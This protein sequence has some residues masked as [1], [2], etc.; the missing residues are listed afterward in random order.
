MVLLY[1]GYIQSVRKCQG[2]VDECRCGNLNKDDLTSENNNQLKIT[3]WKRYIDDI[4]CITENNNTTSILNFLN[5]IKPFLTFTHEIEEKNSLS[6]LDIILTRN[7]SKIETGIYR[8]KT[9]TGGYLNFS[10]FGPI[11]HKISVIKTLSK[12]ISTHCSNNLEKAQQERTILL[13]ELQSNSYPTEFIKR[14]FHRSTF[15]PPSN[16]QSQ[17]LYC[18][19][20]YSYGIE[21]ISRTLKKYNINTIYQTPSNLKTLLRHPDTK[22]NT[23]NSQISNLIYR[24]PC[25]S[26]PA[27]YIG[28]TGKT[29]EERTNQHRTALKNY[30]PL[31]LL[32]D[33]ALKQDHIPNFDSTE[34]VYQN[35]KDKHSRLFLESW[36]SIEDKNSINRKIDIP[37]LYLQFKTI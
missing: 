15:I 20:P 29:L 3:F 23:N 24:I 32:V 10:S 6:F 5:N 31:S 35:I 19:L 1:V 28:E 2:Y 8:K 16:S 34:I 11:N 4:L 33:H 13:N 26:C 37:Q 36:T 30:S 21:R 12:R 27:T 14:Q 17:K 25:R 18:T 9:H 22:H 7:S